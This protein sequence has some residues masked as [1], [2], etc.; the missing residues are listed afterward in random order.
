MK[1]FKQIIVPSL[2]PFHLLL[3]LQDNAY[4]KPII[5]ENERA[6]AQ[7]AFQTGSYDIKGGHMRLVN[8]Q[9][10]LYSNSSST[11]ILGSINKEMWVVLDPTGF[12]SCWIEAGQ[13]KGGVLKNLSQ[14][15]EVDGGGI[16]WSGHFIGYRLWDKNDKTF[17]FHATPFSAINPTGSHTYQI[18]VANESTGEWQV[19]VNGYKALTLQ[20]TTCRDNFNGAEYLVKRAAGVIIGIE[21]K[22]TT[23]SFK[24]GTYIDN[25]FYLKEGGTWSIISQ[26][27]NVDING[28]NGMKSTF[29]FLGS[30][31]KVTFTHN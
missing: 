7:Q 6:Y 26:A 5:E 20:S 10:D 11:N 2:V 24:S 22:D 18:K 14:D 9:D 4:A 3:T 27:A 1:I 25:W 28:Y 19:F 17:E 8:G 21:S 29:S 23:N 30:N 13:K 12:S 16:N 15:D 31:N